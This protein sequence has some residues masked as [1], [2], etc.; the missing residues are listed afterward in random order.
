MSSG[1]QPAQAAGDGEDAVVE[2][3]DDFV[4]AVGD[5]V[6]AGFEAVD[7]E[8]HAHRVVALGTTKQGHAA[9]LVSDSRRFTAPA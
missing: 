2:V 8:C 6:K 7:V 5:R 4:A 9:R 1:E 3:F